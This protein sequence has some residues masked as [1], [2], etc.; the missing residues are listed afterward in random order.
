MIISL[1]KSKRVYSCISCVHNSEDFPTQHTLIEKVINDLKE[2]FKVDQ[3]HDAEHT[4]VSQYTPNTCPTS[5]KVDHF[6]RSPPHSPT[7]VSSTMIPV[8]TLPPHVVLATTDE[9]APASV[10][11]PPIIPILT[12][13][14]TPAAVTSISPQ[15]AKGNPSC[16]CKFYIQG[17][18]QYGRRGQ[19]CSNQH[20][21]MCF[22]VLRYGTR[23]CNKLDC[24]YSHSKM[25]KTALTT[26]RFEGK[27]V[28]TITK[29]EPLDRLLIIQLQAKVAPLFL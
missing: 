9:S 28:S 19:S 1:S 23:W 17:H 27:T 26:G 5:P 21:S 11:L 20:P 2:S 29:P 3:T 25:C 13:E 8:V 22:K 4:Q 24:T 14:L 16:P 7:S 18:C 10:P 6:V 15:H 12:A